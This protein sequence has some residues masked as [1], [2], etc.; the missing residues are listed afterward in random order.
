M[1]ASKRVTCWRTIRSCENRSAGGVTARGPVELIDRLE[2]GRQLGLAGADE[3]GPSVV[4]EFGDGAHRGRYHRRAAGQ[5]F[6]HDHAERL[7]P[8]QRV[9][10]A[11]RVAEEFVL[12]APADLT[13]ELDPGPEQ[14]LDPGAEVLVLGR[15]GELGGDLQGHPDSAR[16]A[17]GD[18]DALVR[19]HASEE[20]CVRLAA[21]PD[22]DRVDVDAMMDDGG[23]PGVVTR[24]R[25]L[26]ARDRD[27]GDS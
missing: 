13:D 11:A 7:R 9:Q 16:H 2:C 5:R 12:G 25:R 10:E 24:A 26:V 1:V 6:D 17:G 4:D 21:G 18:V 8:S 3:A 15:L 20:H 14:W 19:A 22:G 27:Y 23:D